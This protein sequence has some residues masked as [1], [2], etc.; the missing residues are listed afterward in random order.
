MPERVIVLLRSKNEPA[1][2]DA[3]AKIEA[4]RLDY[5]QH[6]PHSSLGHLTPMESLMQRQGT[7]RCKRCDP[8]AFKCLVSGP[9][10]RSRVRQGDAYVLTQHRRTETMKAVIGTL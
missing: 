5:N 3:R 6:R 4:W 10:S 2:D 9:P 7:E 1:G 8:L